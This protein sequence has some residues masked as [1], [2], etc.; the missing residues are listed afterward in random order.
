MTENKTSRRDFAKDI[1]LLSTAGF[2]WE[3]GSAFADNRKSISQERGKTQ[4]IKEHKPKPLRFKPNQLKGISEKLIQSHWENNYQGS[5]KTLNAVRG[6]L[7]EAMAV[8]DYPAFAYGD[9]KREHLLRNG[10]VV[11]HEL[12]FDNLGGNGKSSG[13]IKKQIVQDFGSFDAWEVEFR[14]IAQSLGGGSG[15][16]VLG[17]NLAMGELENYWLWDHMHGPAGALPILVMDMYEH[18]Y[19]MDYGA[20]AAKYIDAFFMNIHWQELEKRWENARKVSWT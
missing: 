1:A 10:S 12:Y 18:S 8:K 2:L 17:Y 14:R 20:A 19:Q 3:G 7:A 11:L 16:V 6:K 15:W 4:V 13:S 9:L 5:V